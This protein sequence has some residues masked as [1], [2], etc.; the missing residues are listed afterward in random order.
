MSVV[1]RT[2]F[3]DGSVRQARR[4]TAA[5]VRRQ[6]RAWLT[7]SGEDGVTR[8]PDADLARFRAWAA[9]NAHRAFTF[10]DETGIGREMRVV[11]GDGGISYEARVSPAGRRIW[12]MEMEMETT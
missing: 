6:I 5:P 2:E 4:F 11:G 9:E 3:D 12:V 7:G 1:E 10:P 8:D